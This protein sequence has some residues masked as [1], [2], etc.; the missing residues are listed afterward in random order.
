[1]FLINRQAFRNWE[2]KARM[3]NKQLSQEIIGAAFEVYNQMGF[4]YLESV[5]EKCL[6]IELRKRGIQAQFQVPLDTYYNEQIVGN[7][8]ADIIVENSFVVELKSIRRLSSIHEAQL[9]NYLKCT[10]FD[11]GLLINFGE[12]KVEVK[13]KIR[14]LSLLN[15]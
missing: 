9:V 7:F 5:Y 14:E 1:M 2:G 6:A 12:Q 3:E 8:F 11:H 15:N 10:G 13:R 4:G